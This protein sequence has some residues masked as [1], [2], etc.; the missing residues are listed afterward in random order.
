M[1]ARTIVLVAG[2]GYLFGT[3]SGRE[4]LDQAK[5]WATRTWNDPKVQAKV[6]EFGTTA[7]RVAKDQGGAIADKVRSAA[8]S[9][10]GD[11]G[12]DRPPTTQPPS[13]P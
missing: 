3:K 6:N 10:E 5:D 4:R 8:A 12:T 13:V 7:A 2:L 1:K 9:G 11:T